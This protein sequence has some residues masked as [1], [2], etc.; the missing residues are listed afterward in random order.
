[1]R[2]ALLIAVAAVVLATPTVAHRPRP[3]PTLEFGPNC[4]AL[5]RA[6]G[7]SRVFVGSVL[8]GQNRRGSWGDGTFRDYRTYQGCFASLAACQTWVARQSRHHPLPP[9]YA[10]CT[11]VFVGLRPDR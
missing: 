10:R 5:A 11:E 9:G 6:T 4:P 2:S 7:R 3:G 8:G 1:M